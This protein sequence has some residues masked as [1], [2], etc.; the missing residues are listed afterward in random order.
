MKK[1]VFISR[2]IIST[3]ILIG[4]AYYIIFGMKIYFHLLGVQESDRQELF[5][6]RG[7]EDIPYLIQTAEDLRLLSYLVNNGEDFY[8]TFFKQTANLDL[9]EENFIPIG[10]F[11]SGHYFWGTYDG[12]GKTIRHLNI[13]GEGKNSALFGQ[14]GGT[15]MNLG[16]ESGLIKGNCIGSIASHAAGKDARII[17]CY[18]KAT[19][20]AT[21]RAGGVADNFGSGIIINCWNE[22][23]I[24][25]P[26]YGE[27]CS[28]TAGMIYSCYSA[29]GEA[30]ND[31]FTGTRKL[32]D[33]P[34]GE[35]LP[36][37]ILMNQGREFSANFLQME[38]GKLSSW[39]EDQAGFQGEQVLE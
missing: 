22:G 16:I 11:N 19:L 2:F 9:D 28:Y 23:N 34:G 33:F 37:G 38:E 7:T 21:G 30:V 18:N 24:S 20:E 27:I 17:N 29:E 3:L 13:S 4:I 5:V 32:F 14:L 15:V 35:V 31:Y 26:V 39:K 36:V 12:N 8:G 10:E 1:I 25:A 6:G